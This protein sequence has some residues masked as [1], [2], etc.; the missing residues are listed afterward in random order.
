[1]ASLSPSLSFQ[2]ED[3]DDPSRALNFRTPTT[4]TT[5]RGHR[6][7]SPEAD[8]PP[9]PPAMPSTAVGPKVFFLVTGF[10]QPP[11]TYKFKLSNDCPLSYL[12]ARLPPT[13]GVYTHK[14]IILNPG[15]SPSDYG[16]E[17]GERNVV[18]L[19][20]IPTVAASEARRGSVSQTRS[21]SRKESADE[22][23]QQKQKIEELEHTIRQMEQEHAATVKKLTAKLMRLQEEVAAVEKSKH[24]AAQD[25][26]VQTKIECM[27]PSSSSM[28]LSSS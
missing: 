10:P 21:Q 11:A 28:P 26:C 2:R 5:G 17:P 23:K 4:T 6:S 8:P 7:P 18:P 24:C 19:R 15:K 9:P 13:R 16:M 27:A 14:N 3:S 1:M 25:V 20:F 22:Q 12:F